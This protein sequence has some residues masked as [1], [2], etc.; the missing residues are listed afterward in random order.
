M[1]EIWRRFQ[2]DSAHYLPKVPEGHKC[3][4]LHGHTYTVELRLAGEIDPVTGW[5]R[6]F[7]DIKD[8]FAPLERELDH[9]LLNDIPGLDNPTSEL[10][11]EWLW[12]HLIEQL[13][14]LVSISVSETPSS[15]VLYTG[16]SASTSA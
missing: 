15:G 2:F 12:R 1:I 11:A 9:R 3:A 16:E 13:P 5:V 4:R 8:V 14:E 7:G 6:D 10:L